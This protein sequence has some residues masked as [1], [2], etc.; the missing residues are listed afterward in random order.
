[1]RQSQRLVGSVKLVRN[2][3]AITS[4]SETGCYQPQG[5]S[6]LLKNVGYVSNV[7]EFFEFR[8]RWNVLHE[9]STGGSTWSHLNH[10][11]V[12]VT[13]LLPASLPVVRTT[14]TLNEATSPGLSRPTVVARLVVP[15]AK[16]P[17]TV[18][19]AAS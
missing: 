18:A 5:A 10:G 12:I 4:R 7:P 8:A 2:G 1:M 14:K 6:G 9:F 17:T 13:V 19:V 3:V 11:R 16:L 15:A